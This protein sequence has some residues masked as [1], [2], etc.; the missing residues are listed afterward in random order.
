MKKIFIIGMT[1]SGKSSLAKKISKKL[2]IPTYD[3]D[4]I[5]W[6]EKYS[7]KK[8]DENCKIELKKILKKETWI[9]EGV[10]DWGK[11]AADKSDLIIWLNYGINICAYRVFKRWLFSKKREKTIKEIY[12]L[13]KYI[14]AYMI[15]RPNKVKSTYQKHTEMIVGNENKLIKINNKKEFNEF[16]TNY[17][18]N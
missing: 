8:D 10:Y 14:R 17:N 18:F 3:L 16:L 6:I 12:G 15:V 7:V 13:I 5:F 2:K 4:D 9:I 11:E 1:G